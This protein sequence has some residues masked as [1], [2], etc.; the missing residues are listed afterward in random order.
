[1]QNHSEAGPDH[2]LHSGAMKLQVSKLCAVDKYQLASTSRD[3]RTRA[4]RNRART[5]MH[6][7]QREASARQSIA[8]TV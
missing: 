4:T 8:S 6:G 1:M 5:E 2:D 7:T 3:K